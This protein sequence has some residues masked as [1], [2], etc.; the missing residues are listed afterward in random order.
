MSIRLS[1][2]VGW[3]AFEAPRTVALWDQSYM[4]CL[5]LR[6]PDVTLSGAVEQDRLNGMLA[7]VMKL[8]GPRWAVHHESQQTRL[9]AYARSEFPFTVCSLLDEERRRHCVS[10][11]RQFEMREV[12]TLTKAPESS[13]ALAHVL[14]AAGES[15]RNAQRELFKREVADITRALEAQKWLTVEKMS[16][17]RIAT[18]L[19]GT[20][21]ANGHKV[22]AADHEVLSDMLPDCR[23]SRGLGVSRLGDQYIAVITVGGYPRRS[24]PQMLAALSA[25]PFEFRWVTR[26]MGMSHAAAKAMMKD[27]E[28]KALGSSAFLKDYFL[29][30][31][32]AWQNK[33]NPGPGFRDG[34]RKRVDREELKHA[35]AAA[36][37]QETLSD[38]A[39][40]AVTTVLTVMDR[41]A[42]T[43]REKRDELV[44]A[45]RDGG[46]M[47]ARVEAL[48]P[49]EPWLMSLPGNRLKGRRTFPVNSRNFVD[50]LQTSSKYR[51]PKADA[52]LAKKTGVERPWL[53]CVDPTGSYRLTTDEPGGV[54]HA[55]VFGQPG[56]GK[57]S[58][59][60]LLCLRF[61]GWPNAQVISFSIGKS[62]IGPCLMTG[63]AVYSPGE[64]GSMALQPFAFVD[65]PDEA[66]DADEWVQMCVRAQGKELNEH[67]RAAITDGVRAMAAEPVE[68]RTLTAFT[69][70][71]ASR[72]PELA[73][74]LEP[75]THRGAYGHIFDGNA[76]HKFAW[77]AW[78]M[79]D[80]SKLVHLSD[81]VTGPALAHLILRVRKRMDGRPTL[82]VMDECPDYL[83]KPGLEPFAIKLVDTSRK[84]EVRVLFAAQTPS[85]I[86]TR[87]PGLLGS[88]QSGV[89]SRIYG[90]DPT[91]AAQSASYAELGVTA[92]MLAAIAAIKQ[93]GRFVHQRSNAA[94]EFETHM[95]PV[96][97]AVTASTDAD[98]VGLFERLAK[99]CS[100][101]D[102][103]LCAWLKHK[104]LVGAAKELG[105]AWT[106]E[107]GTPLAQAAE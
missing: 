82:V 61:F 92:P 57:S 96:E 20:V 23:F 71:M 62:E 104:G 85:Q 68:R 64:R 48:E 95:L 79:F 25:M 88:I 76:A 49:F 4:T 103:L 1:E 15:Y 83:N 17:D 45:I 33:G 72:M 30:Q 14:T 34:Q 44:S 21:S 12:L 100:D 91:A 75:Y 74:V 31:Y 93:P 78:T 105:L 66:L 63:G 6:V 58:L 81:E 65:D 69:D 99:Q 11:G 70:Y 36:A 90:L 41:S 16:D 37:A 101:G 29:N 32:D 19:H 2:V 73:A 53:E 13:S 47:T 84:Q 42:R 10:G 24:R 87:L 80:L 40:G 98:E 50:F 46:K 35:D 67:R 43:C 5:S 106:E 7:D 107:T 55:I 52:R 51:G 18:Y 97:L 60:N 26:W 86:I 56:S 94:R 102:A 39:W 27:R 89:K 54:S 22:S 3:R 28:E 9:S 59:I 38:R 77:R 8:L